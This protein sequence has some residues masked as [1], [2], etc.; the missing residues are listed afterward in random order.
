M[1]GR[2]NYYLFFFILGVGAGVASTYKY[3][4]EKYRMKEEA[5]VESVK[6]YY[7]QLY[8]TEKEGT[9]APE[10]RSSKTANKDSEKNSKSSLDIKRT[11]KK[12]SEEYKSKYSTFVKR[13][14]SAEK[15]YP[16]EDDDLDKEPDKG[17]VE[18]NEED[19]FEID[20][21]AWFATNGYSKT[22]L[23]Y[24]VYN[25]IVT[26]EEDR[27]EEEPEIIDDY[28]IYLGQVLEKSGFLDNDNVSTIYIRNPQ[29][30][31]DYEVS[32][33]YANYS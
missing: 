14:D 25:K 7:R 23:N 9:D 24:Y 4:K 1:S 30:G 29:L 15:E 6:Q 16:K 3:F 28:H 8:R 22:P 11:P 18:D 21:D 20:F 10:R 19:P 17:Y 26:S 32:K 31:A 12:T 33:L 13:P 5:E 27:D 2:G